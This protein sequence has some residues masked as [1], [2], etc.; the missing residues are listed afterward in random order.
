MKKRLS[1]RKQA[2]QKAAAQRSGPQL[3]QA[4]RT[5]SMSR[6]DMVCTLG[7]SGGAAVMA[8]YGLGSALLMGRFITKFSQRVR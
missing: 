2:G 6:R 4:V 8:A 1:V 7:L 3:P 5:G